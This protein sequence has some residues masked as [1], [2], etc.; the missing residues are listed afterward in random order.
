MNFLKQN[1]IT[2]GGIIAVLLLGYIYIVYFSG[3]STPA[4]TSTDTDTALSQ[5][6]LVTLQNLQTIKLDNSIFSDPAFISLTDFGVT[7][8]PQAVGNPDP[9]LPPSGAVSAGKA[10][11][12]NMLPAIQLPT[13]GN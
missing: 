10:G 5:N 13:G 4:L 3:S 2:I 8:P 9:F 1:K 12:S 11:N 6:L 7:I